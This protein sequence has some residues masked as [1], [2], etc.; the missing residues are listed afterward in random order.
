MLH[1]LVV[2]VNA[3][4]AIR[5][6]KINACKMLVVAKNKNKCVGGWQRQLC[7]LR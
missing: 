3:A 1:E 2:R 5:D 4:C 7:S 6:R